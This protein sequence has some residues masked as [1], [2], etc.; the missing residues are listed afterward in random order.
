M[1]NSEIRVQNQQ[2]DY[3]F[4]ITMVGAASVGKTSIIT[5]FCDESFTESYQSTVGVDFRIKTIKV[6]GSL[7]KIQIWDTA[8]QERY[9]ALTSSQYKGAHG[10]ICIF[11]LTARESFDRV[12]EEVRKL[13]SLYSISPECMVIVGNKADLKNW[14]VVSE[15]E[16]KGFCQEINSLYIESSAKEN[17]NVAA[18][19]EELCKRLL[20]N[21][22]LLENIDA[23]NKKLYLERGSDTVKIKSKNCC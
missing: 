22:V 16:A 4:K 3:L 23:V 10:C 19:F 18:I 14:R 17:L 5:R 8:G 12:K 6:G 9:Q 21:N 13:E 11:D 15:E 2:Y 7:V 20:S 1:N